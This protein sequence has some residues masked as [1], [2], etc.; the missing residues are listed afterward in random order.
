MNEVAPLSSR[1]G[2]RTLPILKAIANIV[3]RYATL[4]R[5]ARRGEEAMLEGR[6]LQR[7]CCGNWL[8][9]GEAGLKPLIPTE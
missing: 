3:R 6:Y 4:C 9:L 5:E 7:A 2:L 1:R 8:Q